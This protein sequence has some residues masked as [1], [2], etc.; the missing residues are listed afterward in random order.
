MNRCETKLSGLIFHEDVLIDNA[1]EAVSK[2]WWDFPDSL[3]IRKKSAN[4]A[5][6]YAS[7]LL[8][9]RCFGL[10]LCSIRLRCSEVRS[11]RIGVYHHRI[12]HLL[13]YFGLLLLHRR[14]TM[15]NER[16]NENTQD[17]DCAGQCPCRFFQGS[18][19]FYER[20]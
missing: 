5:F 12:V 14:L 17:N 16:S 8:F 6:R 11:Y 18:P 20:P 19:S 9:G 3:D 13:L 2:V 15:R 4:K 1:N 10:L 7:P